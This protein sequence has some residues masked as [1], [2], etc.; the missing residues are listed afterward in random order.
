MVLFLPSGLDFRRSLVP[1]LAGRRCL[2]VH[3]IDPE[4]VCHI[5]GPLCGGHATRHLPKHHVHEEGQVL[6]RRHLGTIIFYLLSAASR[7]EGSK[8]EF[9]QQL[10]HK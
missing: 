3:G 6:N 5:P 2:D 4:S 1:H 10:T 9:A 7:L 8:G